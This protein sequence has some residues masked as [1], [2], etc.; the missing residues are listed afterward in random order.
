VAHDLNNALGPL[1][2]LPDVIL[3]ELDE[4]KVLDDALPGLRADIECIKAASLRAA[5]T[6]KDL[7]TLGRQGRTAKESLDLNRVVKSSLADISLRFP[8][9]GSFHVRMVVDY[10]PEPLMILGSESQLARAVGNLVRNAVEAIT[11]EGEVLVKTSCVELTTLR[12]GYETIPPGHY[13]TLTVSDDGCG[14]APQEL[15]RVFE[16]FFTKKRTGESSGTGLGLA[17]V[18]GVVKEHAGFID[19]ASTLKEGTTFTLYLPP[20]EKSREEPKRLLGAP[21]GH[22]KILVVDDE[23]SQLLTCR[24]VLCRL[25]YQVEILDSGSRAYELFRQ[26]AQS[27]QSPFDLIVMDMLLNEALDGLQ[28]LEQIQ[29]LFPRQKAIVVSGHA[30]TERAERA[31]QKGLPWLAKPYA[32]DTLAHAVERALRGP[33]S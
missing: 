5:Q 21:R 3:D 12:A 26:A 13:H 10:A 29:G 1:V 31:V 24:R 6:I 32:V 18:H 28:I 8:R 11:G 14:I 7:L 22:S 9:D 17:I 30:P 23:Q 27:G 20:V 2:A 33:S 16:P 15:G 25:G 19:V 4:L